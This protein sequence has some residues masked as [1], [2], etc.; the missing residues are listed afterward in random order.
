MDW[1]VLG[2]APEAV[3]TGPLRER[4]FMRAESAGVRVE[5]LFVLAA[6]DARLTN[7]FATMRAC[8]GY[9]LMARRDAGGPAPEA[10]PGQGLGMAFGGE[11]L[12]RRTVAELVAAQTS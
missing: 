3:T 7:A 12:L 11:T 5:Q 2:L 8:D 6:R 9:R 4:V 1:S 10:A